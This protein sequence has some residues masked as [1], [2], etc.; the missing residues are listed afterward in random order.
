MNYTNL[1]REQIYRDRKRLEDFTDT[2]VLVS[3]IVDNMEDV[4]VFMYG[5][6]DFDSRALLCLNTAYYICTMI[7]LEHRPTRRLSEYYSIAF[8]AQSSHCDE[9]KIAVLSVVDILLRHYDE[10]WQRINEK[11]LGKLEDYISQSRSSHFVLDDDFNT[12]TTHVSLDYI[13][14]QLS[15]GTNLEITLLQDEFESAIKEIPPAILRSVNEEGKKDVSVEEENQTISSL[16]EQLAQRDMRIT[17]LETIVKMNAKIDR[18]EENQATP[19]PLEDID[20]II[21][22][23]LP[24][25]EVLSVGPNADNSPLLAH[26]K[27]LESENHQLLT[28]NEKLKAERDEMEGRYAYESGRLFD[29]EAAIDKLKE[30]LKRTCDKGVTVD[31]MTIELLSRFFIDNNEEVAGDFLEEAKGCDD[32]GIADLITEYKAD[33]TPKLNKGF[34]WS[35]LHAAKLYSSTDRN[36]TAA[37]RKRERE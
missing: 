4:D 23:E 16:Q 18:L 20:A 28:E 21:N 13:Y 36:L 9:F 19:I 8:K 25:E 29:A 32:I 12:S 7:M 22:Q 26:L 10:Q 30:E 15:T 5:D 37:L 31:E 14:K 6:G 1:P 17:E 35:V 34:L 27:E 33:F 11:F 24:S 2:N 3:L